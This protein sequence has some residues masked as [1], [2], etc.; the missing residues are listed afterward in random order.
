MSDY[1]T[2][3]PH[4]GHANIIKYS[5]RPY[6]NVRDMDDDLIKNSN[7]VVKPEDN[8]HILGD[9]CMGDVHFAIDILSELN[10]HIYYIFGNHDKVMR[11]LARESRLLYLRDGTPLRDKVRFL[12]EMADIFVNNQRIILNHYSMRVWNQSHRGAWHLYGHSHGSL[13][14]DPTS[15]SFDVG[16]DC[17]NYKPISFDEIGAIM[18]RKN[19]V[20]IDHHG[21]PKAEG[22]GHY[23]NREEYEKQE[24]KRVYLMLKK[25]FEK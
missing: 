11:Q 2:S 1:F 22:G 16:V 3:D 21:A 25:E 13:S 18:K 7:L 5:N 17:H 4:F 10:G 24:R 8:L 14:D 20:P 9:F 6:R 15:L 12:G 23:W 19:Y